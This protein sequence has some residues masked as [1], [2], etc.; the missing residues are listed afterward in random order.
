M[1]ALFFWEEPRTLA[2][3]PRFPPRRSGTNTGV[4]QM[5]KERPALDEALF[6]RVAALKS[7]PEMVLKRIVWP[8][9]DSDDEE[10]DIEET[11]LHG[12]RLH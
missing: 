2:T 3:F 5:L 9:E 7:D 4:L 10:E 6:P 12:H 8:N 11:C 1:A